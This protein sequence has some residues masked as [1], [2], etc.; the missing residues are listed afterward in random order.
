MILRYDCDFNHEPC[1][2]N[3]TAAHWAVVCG[4]VGVDS[5]EENLYLIACHAKSQHAGVW[6]YSDL[7]ASNDNLRELGSKRKSDGREYIVP[8]GGLQEGIASSWILF[9]KLK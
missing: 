6:K 1:L 5:E 8:A 2:K 7:Q 4:Y 3:G 9:K